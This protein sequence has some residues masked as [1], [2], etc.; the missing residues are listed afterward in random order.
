MTNTTNSAVA[1]LD[2]T[3]IDNKGRFNFQEA[4][5]EAQISRIMEEEQELET[6]DQEIKR[7]KEDTMA[8][9]KAMEAFNSED[10]EEEQMRRELR[11]QVVVMNLRLVTRVISKY[12]YFS[13]D[14]F[15][16]GCVGLLK[17]ADTYNIEKEVPFANYAAFCIETEI[18]FAWKKQT[19]AFESKHK[20][21]LDSIDEPAML[22]NGDAVDRGDMIGDPATAQL[23]DELLGELE[24]DTIF[25]NIIMPCLDEYGVSSKSKGV[26]V[27]R[28]KELQLQYFLEMSIEDSQ[29]SRLTFSEMA[30]EL[31]TT[32]QN[33]RL[34]H[35][36]VVELIREACVDYGYSV[37]AY[38]GI[39]LD[40]PA[41]YGPVKLSRARRKK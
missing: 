3:H 40:D 18:R 27:E 7:L 4:I 35:K 36:R 15:Q 13:P 23:F 25:Y 22:G 16:N 41:G 20:G 39:Y 30:K 6:K 28:W 24:V 2:L 37:G 26:D 34:R 31:G 21:Y 12:G 5:A 19:R 38:G 8:L 10:P 17:A 11:N 14:K 33:L 9:L 32:P 1:N 29:R